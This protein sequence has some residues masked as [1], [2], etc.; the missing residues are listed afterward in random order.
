[1]CEFEE[2]PGMLHGFLLLGERSIEAI[3]VTARLTM[4]QTTEFLQRFVSLTSTWTQ[5]LSSIFNFFYSTTV[6]ATVVV[7][8]IW[9]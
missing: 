1:M 2:L 9:L 5:T 4:K 6:A 7:S 3:A 8:T